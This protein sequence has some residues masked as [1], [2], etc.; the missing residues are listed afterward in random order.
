MPR[1]PPEDTAASPRRH[2]PRWW[3]PGLLLAVS[4]QSGCINIGVMMGKVFFGDPLMTSVF[5][6]RTG[7]SLEKSQQKVAVVCTAPASINSSFDTLQHDL[8]DE[9]TRKLK[10]RNL[11]V[12]RPD[13]VIN[14]LES[15]GGR[16]EKDPFAC[17]LAD[18]KY[19]VHI[20]VEQCTHTEPASPDMYRG[21]ANGIVYVYEVDRSA[22]HC[23][24]RAADVL[25]GIQ[26]RVPR[27]AARDVGPDVDPRFPEEVR[28]IDGGLDRPDVLQHPR[29]AKRSE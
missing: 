7:I 16:F 5:E 27:L 4:L 3:L 14:A 1:T 29:P 19:I 11:N 28:R 13:E 23:G 25:S 12:A 15:T 24:T 8:Q 10:T 22:E 2:P 18:V 26:H 6:Q 21:R 17:S 9:V 20:E